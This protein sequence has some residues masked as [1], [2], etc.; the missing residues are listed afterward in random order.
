M[1][2]V[3]RTW[4]RPYANLFNRPHHAF[5]YQYSYY[6]ALFVIWLLAFSSLRSFNFKFQM[7]KGKIYYAAKNQKALTSFAI[8][9]RAWSSTLLREV[10]RRLPT[11]PG[12]SIVQLLRVF[13]VFFFV[14]NTIK[15]R[16]RL[17]RSSRW[18]E[19]WFRMG[20]NRDHYS[21]WNI[22]FLYINM[23]QC[24]QFIY[25]FRSDAANNCFS[26]SIYMCL[27]NLFWLA[28]NSNKNNI[29]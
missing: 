25:S 20:T 10:P 13:F 27:C 15:D 24:A 17:N 3:L 11:A 14:W 28:A 16:I 23:V 7:A 6:S 29:R 4:V 22:N 19:W 8:W 18:C 12:L 9:S 5:A 21:I 26:S 1:F 2:V